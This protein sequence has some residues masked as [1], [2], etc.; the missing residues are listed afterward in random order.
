MIYVRRRLG[1][2]PRASFGDIFQQY[3][4]PTVSTAGNIL[5]KELKVKGFAGKPDNGTIAP[6]GVGGGG[7]SADADTQSTDTQSTDTDTKAAY[8][9]VI[10]PYG[11]RD[12][13]WIGMAVGAAMNIVGGIFGNAAK[14]RAEARKR[15][16][17]FRQAQL[18]TMQNNANSFNKQM[19]YL[20]QNE[21]TGPDLEYRLGGTPSR[22]RLGA[23]N[24]VITD[25]G[26]ARK[27]GHN[28]FLL[29]GGSHE[30]VNETGQTG[31][32]INVGGNEIEAEG[33]EVAQKKGNTL[34]IFSAQPILK[35]GVS[36]AEAVEAGANK[37][38]VFNAQQAFKRR[39]HL[40][41]DGSKAKFGKVKYAKPNYYHWMHQT[42][43]N[44]KVSPIDSSY[45]YRAYYDSASPWDLANTMYNKNNGHFTDVGKRPNHPTFSN[46]SK[47][48][49]SK[50]PGGTWNGDTFVPSMW[51]FGNNGN[52]VRHRYM[53]DTG[54]S[55][56]DGTRNVYPRKKDRDGD[57]VR[58]YFFDNDSSYIHPKSRPQWNG[59]TSYFQYEL[60][61]TENGGRIKADLGT[62]QRTYNQ[63]NSHDWLYYLTQNSSTG[64]KIVNA[65]FGDE[66]DRKRFMSDLK[67]L[68]INGDDAI[69]NVSPAGLPYAAARAMGKVEQI[70]RTTRTVRQAAEASK[71]AQAARYADKTRRVVESTKPTLNPNLHDVGNRA[72]IPFGQGSVELPRSS[73]AINLGVTNAASRMTEGVNPF[74]YTNRS[75]ILSRAR[76]GLRNVMD[77]T[78]KQADKARQ[79]V[80]SAEL[81]KLNKAVIG[82][83]TVATPL[84]VALGYNTAKEVF[85]DKSNKSDKSAKAE[86]SISPYIARPAEQSKSASEQKAKGN[87]KTTNADKNRSNSSNA[88]TTNKQTSTKHT[89]NV[90]KGNYQLRDGESKVINGTKYTRVGNNIINHKTKVSYVYDSNGNYTGQAD[91]SKVGNNFNDAFDA[92]R[93]A[94]RQNFIYRAGKFNSYTTAKETNAKKESINRIAGAK[95]MAKAFGGDAR[96][97]A[98][99]GTWVKPRYNTSTYNGSRSIRRVIANYEGTDFAKQNAQFHGDAVGA[100]EKELRRF[101]GD[102]YN[103]LNE[104]Q[105]DALLSYYY[106]VKPSTFTSRYGALRD[107]L[108]RASNEVE[109]NDTLNLMKTSINTGMNNNKLKGL[110]K[111]RLYEQGLFGGNGSTT[112]AAPVRTTSTKATSPTVTKA[113]TTQSQHVEVPAAPVAQ[114]PVAQSYQGY[115]GFVPNEDRLFTFPTGRLYDYILAQGNKRQPQRLGGSKRRRCSGGTAVSRP[116]ERKADSTVVTPVWKGVPTALPDQWDTKDM[117]KTNNNM[118]PSNT[119]GKYPYDRNAT[120]K[121]DDDFNAWTYQRTN[122]PND[123]SYWQTMAD[124]TGHTPDEMKANNVTL[125]SDGKVGYNYLTPLRMPAPKKNIW[126]EA[127]NDIQKGADKWQEQT[128]VSGPVAPK[129]GG[130]NDNNT[131]LNG[132]FGNDNWEMRPTNGDWIGLGIDTLSA[133]GTGFIN[134]LYLN[135]ANYDY[136]TPE[137]VAAPD[138]ILDTKY[139]NAAQRAAVERN[140][141]N[142]VKTIM[143]NTGSS[144]VAQQRAQRVNT[145]A[146]YENNRLWDDKMNKELE[147]RNRQAELNANIHAHNA[148]S[149]NNWFN[150]VATIKNKAIEDRNNNDLAKAQAFNATLSGLSQA[151]NNFYTSARQRYE[152]DVAM[153]MYMAGSQYATPSRMLAFGVPMSDGQLVGIMNDIRGMKDPGAKPDKKDYQNA[154]EYSKALTKWEEDSRAYKHKQEYYNLAQ[155]RLSKKGRRR[156]GIR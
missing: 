126:Q 57:S 66:G 24:F 123:S 147:L 109:F 141:L 111:R 135:R 148:E 39:N 85:G 20:R 132:D 31:I 61:K 69:G 124:K 102:A 149:K 19:D 28:T 63:S 121:V 134:N 22:L 104:K 99:G 125:R 37:D 92:A 140:R 41:D 75:Q 146:T 52:S 113:T 71:A 93:A 130:N 7:S 47:Y 115:G 54:E 79:A 84:I 142:N 50:T 62:E 78:S 32:G 103:N 90:T 122:V 5:D 23:S 105:R 49:N 95:R 98:D 67:S 55:Y 137:W 152:D 73:E 46:E 116:V 156:L 108:I 150:T 53:M 154:T 72:G 16:Q 68:G 133:L 65:I 34:R 77:K 45:D 8:G 155:S 144:A 21:N 26:D 120:P 36:P 14:K 13:A 3:I 38:K 40:K 74:L 35:N 101:M 60:D 129:S 117:F 27:I 83:T 100:K 89:G 18:K 139:R 128:R 70:A 97:Q 138:A 114:V 42:S 76:K 58:S 80:S 82:L 2:R 118:Q 136:V 44:L 10:R 94:G 15:E 119:A 25:G 91:Y 86:K 127:N 29:R 11:H 30:D 56:F 59:A 112:I 96:P 17:E 151:Y 43:D 88:T 87:Q 48:S 110:R 64:R 4:A 131:Q 107:K 145:D 143:R 33:G 106:N 12:K 1:T 9:K 51:Q 81:S 6:G 153:R